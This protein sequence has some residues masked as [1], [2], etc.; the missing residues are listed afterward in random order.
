[1]LKYN[2]WRTVP[3]QR[4]W[5]TEPEFD[6]Q[7]AYYGGHDQARY[8]AHMFSWLCGKGDDYR[9]IGG[10][11]WPWSH[12]NQIGPSYGFGS[13]RGYR[14]DWRKLNQDGYAS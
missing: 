7:R 13:E 1:M 10:Q 4:D 14:P 3:P 9:I 5:I 11:A 6:F 2:Y 8:V 12:P